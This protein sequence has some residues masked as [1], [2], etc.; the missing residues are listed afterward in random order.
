M[1]ADWSK[2]TIVLIIIVMLGL[3]GCLETPVKIKSLNRS[4]TLDIE[5]KE[6]WKILLDEYP[7]YRGV[8]FYKNAGYGVTK[9]SF[10]YIYNSGKGTILHAKNDIDYANKS[11]ADYYVSGI[12]VLLKK[13]SGEVY[14]TGMVLFQK[15]ESTTKTI[16]LPREK[17]VQFKVEEIQIS[18]GN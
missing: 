18:P 11:R 2:F 7:L 13:D 15:D 4:Q 9:V 8:D 6:D 14:D 17:F 3:S 16:S 1:N 10:E 12:R 5:G